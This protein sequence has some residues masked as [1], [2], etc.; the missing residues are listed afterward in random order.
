M[1]NMV[2]NE[3]SGLNE[4]GQYQSKTLF[5]FPDNRGNQTYVSYTPLIEQIPRRLSDLIDSVGLEGRDTVNFRSLV[6]INRLFVTSPERM[7]PAQLEC[8]RRYATSNGTFS[9]QKAEE[10]AKAWDTKADSKHRHLAKDYKEY[11]DIHKNISALLEG[12]DR[13][14][15]I[16][17]SILSQLGN[18]PEYIQSFIIGELSDIA[19]GKSIDSERLDRIAKITKLFFLNNVSPQAAK[20]MEYDIANAMTCCLSDVVM[21]ARFPKVFTFMEDTINQAMGLDIWNLYNTELLTSAIKTYFSINQTVSDKSMK[22][23]DIVGRAK[24]MKSCFDCVFKNIGLRQLVQNISG[25]KTIIEEGQ[26]FTVLEKIFSDQEITP[27]IRV[28]QLSENLRKGIRQEHDKIGC[29]IKAENVQSFDDVAGDLNK[30]VITQD[31]LRN[32][33]FIM[34]L[35]IPEKIKP[36]IRLVKAQYPQKGKAQKEMP[37]FTLLR[38]KPPSHRL[39]EHIIQLPENSVG[40]GAIHATVLVKVLTRS[41]TGA[42]KERLLPMEVQ[43]RLDGNGD[44]SRLT[45]VSSAVDRTRT[46]DFNKAIHVAG[47]DNIAQIE[48][49][50]KSAITEAHDLLGLHYTPIPLVQQS[51]AF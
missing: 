14:E 5:P 31:T 51:A 29:R 25:N 19:L 40:Y 28:G 35:L 33:G 21:S 6:S 10:I 1:H 7:Y 50:R 17:I 30:T 2:F 18:R 9:A 41:T 37:A 43:L 38:K 4:Q 49:V 20:S 39:L 45:N 15:A 11:S 24:A 23:T 34:G 42:V 32:V 26:L 27:N 36:R 16:T 46:S 8:L 47:F 48:N 3:P 13:P 22:E 44:L 12:P